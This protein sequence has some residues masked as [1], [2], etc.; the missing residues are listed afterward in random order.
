MDITDDLN[1][2]MNDAVASGRN[3]YSDFE[4]YFDGKYG[5]GWAKEHAD[6]VARM[7][8]VAATEFQTAIVAK[9]LSENGWTIRGKSKSFPRCS[10]DRIGTKEDVNY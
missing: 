4:D 6:V 3:Y 8:K 5:A 9:V 2:L 1:K 7:C 10:R